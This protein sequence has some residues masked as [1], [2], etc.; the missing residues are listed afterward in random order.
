QISF[1]FSSSSSVFCGISR[2]GTRTIPFERMIS[3]EQP[4]GPRYPVITGLG[5]IA[6]PGCHVDDI[7]HAIAN[8]SSG[9][10]PLSLVSSPRHGAVPVGE[11]QRGL[12]AL[13]APLRGSRRDRL[14]WLAARD[15]I[16]SAG[17]N[18]QPHADRAGVVLGCS[19]GGSFDSERFLITLMHQRK[20]RS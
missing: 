13:G 8:N 17:I 1:S 12:R 19:V 9:L 5:I 14:G 15:A 20:M 16:R 6:A 18:F 4:V 7:W 11:I 2:T 3:T 10:K